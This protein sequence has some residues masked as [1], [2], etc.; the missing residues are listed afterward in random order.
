M[1]H[2]RSTSETATAVMGSSLSTPQFEQPYGNSAFAEQMLAHTQQQQG[3]EVAMGRGQAAGL[4]AG[5]GIAALNAVGSGGPAALSNP[6]DFW[7]THRELSAPSL[8]QPA[9]AMIRRP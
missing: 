8:V 9:G 2:T 6:N 3:E 5:F 7:G 4:L 1:N